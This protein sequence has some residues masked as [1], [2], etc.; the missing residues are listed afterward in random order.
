MKTALQKAAIKTKDWLWLYVA[1]ANEM[2]ESA[3]EA[4][5]LANELETAVNLDMSLEQEPRDDHP[6]LKL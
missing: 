4:A 3:R 5:A 6:T 2:D 1:D